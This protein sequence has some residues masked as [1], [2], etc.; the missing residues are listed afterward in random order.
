LGAYFLSG[1]SFL[2]LTA[3]FLS[4][5]V[6]VIIT[7]KIAAIKPDSV[8]LYFDFDFF[9]YNLLCAFGKFED[10]SKVIHFVNVAS[11]PSNPE[12]PKI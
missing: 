11:H 1:S 6:L 10:I 3:N 8:M 2:P 5:A 12:N 9:K 4:P 7:L